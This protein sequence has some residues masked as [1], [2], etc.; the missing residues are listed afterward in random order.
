MAAWVDK[1]LELLFPGGD[2]L[3]TLVRNDK[4]V[5]LAGVVNPARLDK[6][7]EGLVHQLEEI[8]GCRNVPEI[9]LD[10]LQDVL[11]VRCLLSSL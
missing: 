8:L 3:L 1:L 4:E 2:P 10:A 9:C 6:P 7:T 5:S 11:H